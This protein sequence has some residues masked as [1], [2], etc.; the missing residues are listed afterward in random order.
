M[1]KSRPHKPAPRPAPKATP[2]PPA[3]APRPAPEPP[4]VRTPDQVA[5]AAIER[6]KA[7]A[8]DGFDSDTWRRAIA[9]EARVAAGELLR[10]AAKVAGGKAGAAILDQLAGAAG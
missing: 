8:S 9:A 7:L 1:P 4:K 10:A 6:F 3:R 5:D 2:E